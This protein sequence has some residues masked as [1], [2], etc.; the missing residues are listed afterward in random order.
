VRTLPP[1]YTHI[2]FLLD[3]LAE[4]LAAL[5]VIE[6]WGSDGERW[7]EFM[8]EADKKPEAP[9]SIRGFLMAVNDCRLARPALEVPDWVGQELSTRAK[10]MA[11]PVNAL[12]RPPMAALTDCRRFAP[13]KSVLGVNVFRAASRMEAIQCGARALG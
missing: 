12:C 11:C 5:F 3:P 6:K 1:A 7:E 4:Y 2:E 8:K 9:K 10:P 13:A